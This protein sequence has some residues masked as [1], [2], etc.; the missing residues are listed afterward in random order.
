MEIANQIAAK[1]PKR[2]LEIARENLKTRYTSALVNTIATLREKNPEMAAELAG[3]VAT[4]LLG[5]KLTKNSQAAS[6]VV[7]LIQMSGPAGG[8]QSAETNGSPRRTALLSDQQRRDLMQKALNE[9]LAFKTSN[10][11]YHTPDRDYAWGL[12]HGLQSLGAEVDTVMNGSS[13]AITKKFSE[14]TATNSAQMPGVQE[15][16][17]AINNMNMPIDEVIQVLSKAPQQQKDQ[18]FIQLSGRLQNNGDMARAKQIL[19]DYVTTPYQRQQALYN[20]EIQEMYRAM[21]KGKV[22]E[23]LRS[24]S[25]LPTAQERA[26]ALMQMANQIG[27]GLKRTA[28][29]TFLDQARGLLPPSVQAQDY[30]QMQAL[31]EI[32]KAYSR[33]DVKRA[34]EII[35]PLIDQFNE[36]SA[37]ARIMEGFAGEFYDQEELNLQNGNMVGGVASQL[38]SALGT[39]ALTN[40]DRAK[41]TADRIRLPEVRLRAYLDI[42]QQ[43]IQGK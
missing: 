24:V 30:A 42:A 5:E 14:F 3:E 37:A 26:Q 13:T 25:T 1:D 18:L 10:S 23:A 43:A 28:A 31:V 21:S 9:A 34:F 33:Y 29:L 15:Y 16:Y 35:D 19:N 27:P 22:E 8:N 40:F 2:T 38:T 32:A 36:L 7:G 11:I 6:L 12:L 41:A 20:L 17:D 39:F 4:K